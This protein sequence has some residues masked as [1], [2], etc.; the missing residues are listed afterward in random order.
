MSDDTPNKW[1]FSWQAGSNLTWNATIDLS[2]GSPAVS[3]RE[4]TAEPVQAK[5]Q[6]PGIVSDWIVNL[7]PQTSADDL[8]R[9]FD[10]ALIGHTAGADI[11]AC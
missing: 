5:L 11:P 2:D 1:Q 10:I 7:A 3:V 6:A 8:K 9:W 4:G